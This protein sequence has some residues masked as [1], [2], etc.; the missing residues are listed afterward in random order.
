MPPISQFDLYRTPLTSRYTDPEMQELFSD[1]VKFTKWR[2]LWTALAQAQHELGAPVTALQAK[3]LADHVNIT[4]DEIIAASA[5]EKKVRHD[6]VAHSRTYGVTCPTAAPIIHL[7]CTSMYVCDN[8]DLITMR[9]A[10]GMITI[11][12]VKCLDRMAKQ[13]KKWASQPTLAWTHFQPAQPI[14]VGKRIA[15]WMQ[16]LLMDYEQLTGIHENMKFLG[17]KGAT[18]TQDSYLK[19]F[20]GNKAKVQELDCMVTEKFGFKYCASNVCGQTYTRKVDAI[21]ISALAGVSSSVHK[22]MLDLRLLQHMKEVEEPFEKGQVG[23]SAMAYKRNPM[24]AERADGLARHGIVLSTEAFMTH[25]LQFLERTLDD[26][27]PRRIYIPEAFLT[28]DAVLTI[29][30][31]VFENL[32]VYPKVIE[33]H[34]REELP[35]M[36]TEDIIDA[37]VKA[38]KD[39]SECHERL[40]VIAQEA[41][42][43]I[44]ENGEDN[45]FLEIAQQDPFFADAM[46]I[47]KGSIEPKNF[48]G[49]APEQTFNFLGDNI[50]PILDM[51]PHLLEGSS[52]LK[53]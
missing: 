41:G 46:D 37:M 16:D 5:L 38:G 47:L 51:F 17:A 21:I 13:A 49:R 4:D 44:K 11:K 33:K 35:F 12:I 40:R 1:R 26:S 32:V 15:V 20:N 9:D 45:R 30:Q 2:M 19:L 31:N 43:M 24:R 6:V 14:T 18:G 7:A 29:V 8:T 10:L 25:A 42:R 52:E 34:L 23:S 27:A 36:V 3:E 50:Q 22:M 48:I 39:R 53:V 28:A